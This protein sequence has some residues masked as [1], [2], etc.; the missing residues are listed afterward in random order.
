[1][2]LP[3]KLGIPGKEVLAPVTLE[4]L[5]GCDPGI[6]GA[7]TF[8]T[9]VCEVPDTFGAEAVADGGLDGEAGTGV[10]VTAILVSSSKNAAN[11]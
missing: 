2:T 10:P 1:M 11:T 6:W 7:G 3:A 8:G 5:A 4:D 9:E